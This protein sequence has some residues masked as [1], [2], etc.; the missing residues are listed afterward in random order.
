MRI[1]TRLFFFFFACSNTAP[2]RVECEGGKTKAIGIGVP[3][4]S[5][6][7]SHYKEQI[8]NHGKYLILEIYELGDLG[9]RGKVKKLN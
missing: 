4:D 6:K 2:V 5:I 3:G 8:I 9:P 7:M 1:N